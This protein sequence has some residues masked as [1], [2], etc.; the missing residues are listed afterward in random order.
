MMTS[1]HNNRIAFPQRR[2]LDNDY[3]QNERRYSQRRRTRKAA[4]GYRSLTNNILMLMAL[5][6]SGF[7][8]SGHPST[9]N[10]RFISEW[11]EAQLTFPDGHLA[12]DLLGLLL[13]RFQ[14]QVDMTQQKEDR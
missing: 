6:A 1:A 5:P 8:L 3:G 7:E 12:D 10:D 2:N 13:P 14:R 4:N 11:I 9:A